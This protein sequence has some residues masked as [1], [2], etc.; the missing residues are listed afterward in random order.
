MGVDWL[1]GN[2]SQGLRENA[3]EGGRWRRGPLCG[4]GAA[5]EEAVGSGRLDSCHTEMA[6]GLTASCVCSLRVAA[7]VL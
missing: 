6:S 7:A 4:A 2:G 1:S 3:A 5:E